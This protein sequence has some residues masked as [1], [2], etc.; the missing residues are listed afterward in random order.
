MSSMREE[1]IR[2]G[3][4]KSAYRVK[5]S[6]EKKQGE[7]KTLDLSREPKNLQPEYSVKLSYEKTKKSFNSHRNPE[8]L[9]GIP[10]KPY[11]SD[12]NNFGVLMWTCPLCKARIQDSE[13]NKHL[14]SFHISQRA[15]I[16]AI[17]RSMVPKS[18]RLHFVQ[19]GSPG[20]KKR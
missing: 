6:N 5:H 11:A 19:G 20:L 10:P 1:L 12:V 16:S 7:V 3:L 14:N 13:R 8:S 15:N 9:H 4:I 17:E 2:L 18:L